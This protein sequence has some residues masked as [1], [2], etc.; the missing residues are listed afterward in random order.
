VLG[1]NV[2][3]Y[4][5]THFTEKLQDYRQNVC[6]DSSDED[7][8]EDDEDDEDEDDDEDDEDDCTRRHSSTDT[9]TPA[10]LWGVGSNHTTEGSTSPVVSSTTPSV[11]TTNAHT[12]SSGSSVTG[13]QVRVVMCEAC[14]AP[15]AREAGDFTYIHIMIIVAVCECESE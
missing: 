15:L 2:Y 11:S 1:F 6:N 3:R 14:D 13:G 10:P 4:L 12:V 5:L 7:D 8:D 9:H